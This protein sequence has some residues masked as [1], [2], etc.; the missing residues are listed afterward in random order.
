MSERDYAG[1]IQF[2]K[3]E[4]QKELLE[5]IL[6]AGSVAKA[7]ALLQILPANVY[8]AVARI[9][10][11]AALIAKGD[12]GFGAKIPEGHFLKRLSSLEKMDENGDYQPTMRWVISNQRADDAAACLR[13][14]VD[15]LVE[16][17]PVGP[18]APA[19]PKQTDSDSLT[20]YPLT[21]LH[22]GMLAWGKECGEDYDLGIA[23][24][25][26]REAAA[27]CVAKSPPSRHAIIAN[28][29]DFFHFDNDLKRTAASGHALDGDGRWAKVVDLGVQ[30]LLDFVQ[31]ALTKHREVKIINS[32][33]NHDDQ[34]AL[35]IPRI[36]Q[37]YFAKNKRVTVEMSPRF[38]HYHIFGANLLGFHHGHKTPANRL[39]MTMVNDVLLRR[40]SDNPDTLDS[41]AD[42]QFCHWLTGHVHHE[43]TEYNGI[44]VESFRTLAA[45]DSYAASSGYRAGRDI[46]TVTYDRN[47]GEISR[48][49]IPYKM[50]ANSLHAK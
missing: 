38:H 48:V 7:A 23:S 45:K 27:M 20:V 9:E 49:R 5:C 32:I 29:G 31:V 33:G 35:M 15:G 44:L 11:H 8:R 47:Y 10:K 2:C 41:P 42:I 26:A 28:L 18:P 43:R 46:Q 37:P 30:I 50:I 40:P 21:D 16:Y 36:L 39:P 13:E 34:S 19:A 17:V 24:R 4:R 12:P 22:L 6:Q 1:L 14:F 3:T 25:M